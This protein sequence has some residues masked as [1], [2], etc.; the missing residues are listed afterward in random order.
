MV[1]IDLPE[2]P[3][4]SALR[5]VFVERHHLADSDLTAVT[6]HIGCGRKA[7]RQWFSD[8]GLALAHAAEMADHHALP[9]FDLGT[10]GEGE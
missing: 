6:V 3:R 10:S 9:L 8:R 5:A 4:P 1:A 2:L 7:R